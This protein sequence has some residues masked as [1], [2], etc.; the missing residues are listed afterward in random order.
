MLTGMGKHSMA[1]FRE[2]RA[3]LGLVQMNL[4]IREED[5]A[6]FTAA[7]EPFKQR[8]GELDPAQRRGRKR[9]KAA[10]VHL[11]PTRTPTSSGTPETPADER[12]TPR[13]A[14]ALPCRLIFPTAPPA[15]ICN[16]MKDEGWG[17]D[18]LSGVWTANQADLVEIWLAE[19]TAVW[20]ARIIGPIADNDSK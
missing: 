17:Y 16:A 20:H 12:S 19:L 11:E 13:P 1:S 5:R 7:V 8:A 10:R 9:Q 18:K 3:S 6:A 15:H 2:R 14:I 4:W